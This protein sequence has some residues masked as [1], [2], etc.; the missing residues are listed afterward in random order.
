[1]RWVVLSLSIA[2]GLSISFDV[3]PDRPIF[4]G[5]GAIV[6]GHTGKQAT[7]V[8]VWVNTA[9]GVYH[10]PGTRYF[11]ATKRG[12]YLSEQD[13]RSQGYRG[14]GGRACGAGTSSD[15]APG[16]SDRL[17]IAEVPST[18]SASKVW[19]NVRSGVYHCPGT[20]Y[21]GATK[22]GKYM[23]EKAARDSAYRPAYGRTC[24]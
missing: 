9:S 17:G 6:V 7:S 3:T 20:R 10:C 21:Y 14:A 22:S 4:G 11:G 18:N 12:K 16:S 24:G 2:L 5:T 1:M 8:R 19:V 15:R 13:A 23:T